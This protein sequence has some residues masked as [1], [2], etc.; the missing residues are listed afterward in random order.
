MDDKRK[1][2]L[3]AGVI[4]GAVIIGLLVLAKRTPREKWGETMVR[5]A[6]DVMRFARM[7]Y[8]IVAK[9]LFDVAE[10]IIERMGEKYSTTDTPKI[11]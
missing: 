11:A 1:R 4:I 7:R 8:G 5:V 2:A 6:H 9:P 3:T 10:Q